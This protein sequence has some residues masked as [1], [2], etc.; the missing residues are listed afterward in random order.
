VVRDGRR[1]PS[2]VCGDV[3]AGPCGRDA[4]LDDDKIQRARCRV[5]A[6]DGDRRRRL[7]DA[8]RSDGGDRRR[9]C[10]IEK[11]PVEKTA[12]EETHRVTTASR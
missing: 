2:A 11:R 4:L 9:D 8:G 1:R 3:D 6:R 12:V 5:A 10:R 7:R